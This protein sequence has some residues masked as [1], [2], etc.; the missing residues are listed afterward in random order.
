MVA[1]GTM[2]HFAQCRSHGEGMRCARR[3]RTSVVILPH[4]SRSVG[5]RRYRG[6]SRSPRPR[7]RAM[8]NVPPA[9]ARRERRCR[10]ECERGKKPVMG[11]I[12]AIASLVAIALS[13]P[14]AGQ[15]FPEVPLYD[16][17]PDDFPYP[18]IRV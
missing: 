13:I 12:I 2:I 17:L 15:Q 5:D 3:P 10:R 4:E 9:R 18:I 8:A 11:R 16:L 6:R 7:A 14:V 1:R